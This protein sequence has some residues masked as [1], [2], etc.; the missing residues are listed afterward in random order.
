MVNER[1][2]N[3]SLY[4][5]SGLSAALGGLISSGISRDYNR[6][7]AAKTG[8]RPLISL[9]AARNYDTAR[10]QFVVFVTPIIKSSASLGVQRIKKKFQVDKD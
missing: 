1:A 4:V 8:G 9:F 2:I 5:R 3:T 10:T 6:L 7:P